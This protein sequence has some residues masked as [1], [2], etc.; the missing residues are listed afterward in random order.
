IGRGLGGGGPMR[1]RPVMWMAA[2]VVVA[3]AL[4]ALFGW[5]RRGPGSGTVSPPKLTQ[6]TIREGI[7]D[8]PAF[9]PDS[10]RLAFAADSG[11]VRHIV[12]KDLGTGKEESL[13]RGDFDEIQPAWSRDGESIFF[14]RARK[15]ASRLE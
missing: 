6:I 14:V 15:P 11:V 4:V 3:L 10:R 9:S 7:E 13:T 12:I 5:L 1:S 8:F 2:S